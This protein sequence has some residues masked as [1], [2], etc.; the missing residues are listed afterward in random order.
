MVRNMTSG[1]P[2]RL[3]LTFAIPLLIGNV[4]QQFYNIADVIIVGRTIGVNALAAVGAVAPAFMG[5]VGL[6]IGLTSGFTVITGQCF[7]AGDEAG[8]RR[9]VTTSAWLSFGITLFLTVAVLLCMPLIMRLMNIA[10]VIYQDAYQYMSIVIG[11]LAA[12]MSYNLLACICRALGDS[13]TPLYFLILSSLLNIVLALTFIILLGWG[14]AGSAI[15][16]VIAQAVSA[17]LCLIYMGWRFPIL[18]L[19][20]ADWRFNWEFAWRHLR[21]GVPMSLQFLIISLGILVLQSVCNTFGPET[22]AGFVSATRIEQLAMQPMISFGIAMAVFSAQN[23]G[24]RKYARIYQGVR[25]CSLVSLSFCILAAV[26]MYFY[27]R[28]LIGLFTAEHDEVLLENALLYLKL[29]V[30]CYVFLGQIFVYRNAL[31]G[32]GIASVPLISGILELTGRS[33]S[34]LVLAS[35]WGFFGICCASPICWIVA[36]L[37]TGGSYFYV[38]HGMKKRGLGI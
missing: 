17:L 38:R 19:S 16:L 27:G 23:F 34:A 31:Q 3:I 10:P 20:R 6:T 36:C 25:Q 35:F 12:M 28:E 13:R 22:I 33:V 18:R 1:N 5:V 8:V 9:S 32:M 2:I 24:A 11:G 37:F 29:S 15:A 21:L 14:V 4:F 7:G 26:V 30:P